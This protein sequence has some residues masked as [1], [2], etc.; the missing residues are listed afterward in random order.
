M[1][2]PT[3]EVSRSTTLSRIQIVDRTE[4]GREFIAP[5]TRNFR[6]KMP[7]TLV[8][9]IL[10]AAFVFFA[11]IA[12]SFISG[13]P[14]A[15]ARFL[16]VNLFF[17]HFAILAAVLALLGFVCVDMLFRSTRVVAV[18]G[19]LR[20][21]THWLFVRRTTVMPVSNIIEITA[22]NNTTANNVRYYDITVAATGV[23]KNRLAK[24]VG[25]FLQAQ[26]PNNPIS[27]EKM[28]EINFINSGG[29]KIRA[30]T[31]IASETDANA[32]LRELNQALGRD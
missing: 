20:V 31:D 12:G 14:F 25:A 15:W 19:E 32:I 6:E 26:N 16:A 21:A 29:K 7:F 3:Q 28:K 10:A 1:S 13:L 30:I 9:L 23:G 2:N 22:A 17:Y 5:A 18:P 11:Y 24:W 4:G 27:A 8:L